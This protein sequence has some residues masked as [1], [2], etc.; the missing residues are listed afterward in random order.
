MPVK[1]KRTIIVWK[2]KHC[3]KVFSPDTYGYE[4]SDDLHA[5]CESHEAKCP[6]DPSNRRCAACASGS[7]KAA[8]YSNGWVGFG[9]IRSGKPKADGDTCRYWSRKKG[10]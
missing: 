1:V 3:G 6:H 10:T 9:C 4:P 5:D 8:A 7:E 2:C